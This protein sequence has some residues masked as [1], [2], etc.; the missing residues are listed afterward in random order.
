MLH[1][2]RAERVHRTTGRRRHD[3]RIMSAEAFGKC[4]A[5]LS[6][7]TR[8]R[9]LGVVKSRLT[10]SID[11]GIGERG[12]DLPC[13]QVP[14][15]GNTDRLVDRSP[16]VPSPVGERSVITRLIIDGWGSSAAR[17]GQP[18]Q[19]APGRPSRRPG[20]DHPRS[21][22]RRRADPVR[23]ARRETACH[24]PT[25]STMGPCT[26]QMSLIGGR[27]HADLVRPQPG[28]ADTTAAAIEAAA[29]LRRTRR[30]VAGSWSRAIWPG[31]TRPS[32]EIQAS[33]HWSSSLLR[34]QSA[35]RETPSQAQRR[36][37]GDS[38]FRRRYPMMDDSM[39]DGSELQTVLF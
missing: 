9:P 22:P 33:R 15:P 28:V 34:G 3:H 19:R 27:P 39:T 26:R 25:T 11:R 29:S 16:P 8:S 12:S 32:V 35:I 36:H 4:R 14:V 37:D 2:R 17:P 23:V 30:S 13:R 7:A 1:G 5:L 6:I 21:R 31:S 18:T 24:A 20:F 10:A 38:G